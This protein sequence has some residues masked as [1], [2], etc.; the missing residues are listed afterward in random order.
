MRSGKDYLTA[1]RCVFKDG[2]EKKP[3]AQMMTEVFKLARRD[4]VVP[5]QYFSRFLYRKNSPAF[6]KFIDN[7]LI[8]KI[9]DIQDRCEA[10]AILENKLFTFFY[11]SQF[12]IPMP[13]MVAYNQKN[14]FFLGKSVNTLHDVE[15]FDNLFRRFFESNPRNKVLF[16]KP[17]QGFQGKGIIRVTLTDVGDKTKM[18]G[19]FEVITQGS[20]IIQETLIQ[21]EALNRINPSSINTIRTNTYCD[22]SG[23]VKIISA[24]LR[25]GMNGSYVDNANSGG[26]FAG[27]NMANGH[28]KK[29]AQ[30]EILFGGELYDAHPDSHVRF[31]GFALPFFEDAMQ[32]VRKAHACI[33][34]IPL[35]GWDV[36][37]TTEGPVILEGNHDFDIGMADLADGG[38]RNNHVFMQALKRFG[39]A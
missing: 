16:V 29:N 25:M 12:D 22:E 30:R 15:A 32:M 18:T 33:P 17:V 27:I 19:Y 14:T 38:Y 39:L 31:E 21:H 8:K 13:R 5:E 2:I 24:L 11:F 6:D 26:C 20:Y 4:R 28:L 1:L 9:H 37:L 23:E 35:V 36:A 7:N 3:V 10:K 34:E